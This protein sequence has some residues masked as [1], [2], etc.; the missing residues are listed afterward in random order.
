MTSKRAESIA[1]HGAGPT[2]RFAAGEVRRIEHLEIHYFLGPPGGAPVW[3]RTGPRPRAN[4]FAD[5]LGAAAPSAVPFGEAFAWPL[6]AC[7]GGCCGGCGG[8][9]VFTLAVTELASGG[10]DE[11]GGCGEPLL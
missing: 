5:G 7:G 6:L 4:G 2:K 3:T 1:N 10:D 8:D 9:D 11:C